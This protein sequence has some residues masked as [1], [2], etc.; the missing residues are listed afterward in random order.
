MIPVEAA[1]F[2]RPK[3][4]WHYQVEMNAAKEAVRKAANEFSPDLCDD[5]DMHDTSVP[6]LTSLAQT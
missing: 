2:L 6:L 1:S 5:K 3:E 4:S